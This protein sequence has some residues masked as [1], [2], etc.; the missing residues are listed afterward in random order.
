MTG[1]GRKVLK[2]WGSGRHTPC[3]G[4]MGIKIQGA[5]T[6]GSGRVGEGREGA[7]GWGAGVALTAARRRLASRTRSCFVLAFFEPICGRP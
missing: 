6:R 1:A 4:V 2:G 5:A 3:S 7:G